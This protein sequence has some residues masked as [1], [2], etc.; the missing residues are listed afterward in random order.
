MRRGIKL[1]I[2]IQAFL[3][4]AM[5][6]LARPRPLFCANRLVFCSPPEPPMSSSPSPGGFFSRR[7]VFCSTSLDSPAENREPSGLQPFLGTTAT[8]NLHAK[9]SA[10]FIQQYIALVEDKSESTRV[11][12]VLINPE[13]Q[14]WVTGTAPMRT[15]SAV[16]QWLT[17]PVRFSETAKAVRTSLC[18]ICTPLKRGVNERVRIPMGGCD[19]SRFPVLVRFSIN[20]LAQGLHHA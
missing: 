19:K 12:S 11:V 13:L 10:G 14:L 3:L 1:F 7:I 5:G 15:V 6:V 18:R 17:G 16:Y 20:W 9:R 2:F 8:E 4:W